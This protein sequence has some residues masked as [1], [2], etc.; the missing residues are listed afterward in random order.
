M[1]PEKVVRHTLGLALLVTIVVLALSACSGGG[2]EQ[3]KKPRRLP[4]DEK[5]L[6]A[7]EYRTKEFKPSLSF[8][9][10]KGWSTESHPPDVPERVGLTWR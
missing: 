3:A 10:G 8:R 1:Y 6:H 7:G 4:E 5:P 9:V 2:Q